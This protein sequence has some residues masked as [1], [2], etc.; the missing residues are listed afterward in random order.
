MWLVKELMFCCGFRFHATK[1]QFTP[2][3]SIRSLGFIIDTDQLRFI[4]LQSR[5]DTLVYMAATMR[6]WANIPTHTLQRFTGICAFILIAGPALKFFLGPVFDALKGASNLNTVPVSP[7]LREALGE[8]TPTAFATWQKTAHWR[9][10]RHEELRLL[11]ARPGLHTGPP[12]V[13]TTVVYADACTGGR[14]GH[15]GGWG[16]VI[17]YADGSSTVHKA[18]FLDEEQDLDIAVLESIA[19]FNMLSVPAAATAGWPYPQ[20]TPRCT[21]R[22]QST[23]HAAKHFGL[24]CASW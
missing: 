24:T 9:S 20:T 11:W 7:T 21:P 18:A 1:C 3:T 10:E 19:A 8:F 23:T 4:V 22:C 6:T 15:V 12:P 16:G 2:S 17:H 13:G 14:A 5:I